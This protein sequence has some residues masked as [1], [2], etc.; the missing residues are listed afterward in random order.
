[1]NSYF[2]QS[3]YMM[4]VCLCFMSTFLYFSCASSELVRLRKTCPSMSDTDLLNYYYGINERL[5]DIDNEMKEKEP[6]GLTEH[7]HL[8]D[9]DSFFAGGEGYGLIQKRKVILEELHKRNIYP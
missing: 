7:E 4:I 6:S 2:K 8:M 1:M 9:N 3:Y 5:K